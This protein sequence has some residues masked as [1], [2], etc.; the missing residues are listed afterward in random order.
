MHFV[1][2]FHQP[3]LVFEG[4][5]TLV[6]LKSDSFV[7]YIFV[8]LQISNLRDLLATERTWQERFQLNLLAVVLL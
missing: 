5:I 1:F 6:T 8:A 2:M 3:T 4:Q 7:H